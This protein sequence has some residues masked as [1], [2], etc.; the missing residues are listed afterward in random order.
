MKQKRSKE[1]VYE[2]V[3]Q[4]KTFLTRKIS[5]YFILALAVLVL[6]LFLSSR[7]NFS[8]QSIFGQDSMI[9]SR[10]IEVFS[11]ISYSDIFS[12]Y[13]FTDSSLQDPGS[14]TA[15][16]VLLNPYLLFARLLSGSSLVLQII[17]LV[18]S[19]LSLW[20]FYILLR[21]LKVGKLAS[22]LSV[23][24][25]AL[26][27]VFI[28][29]ALSISSMPLIAFLFLVSGIF[30]KKERFQFISYIVSIIIL[31]F[32]IEVAIAYLFFILAIL[33][34]LNRIKRFYVILFFMLVC[35]AMLSYFR[36]SFGIADFPIFSSEGIL[37]EIVSEFGGLRSI[38][39]MTLAVFCFE[40]VRKFFE[41]RIY[42]LEL[43]LIAS[44]VTIFFYEFRIYYL[45]SFGIALIAAS[46]ISS[47][48]TNRW[49]SETLRRLTILI[50][51]CGI[52]F[53][54]ISYSNVILAVEPSEPQIE[55]LDWLANQDK[56]TVFSLP[57]KS[58]IIRKYSS[59]P[60]LIDDTSFNPGVNEDFWVLY[61]SRDLMQTRQILGKHNV[62][63]IWIDS[64]MKEIVW[65]KPDDGLL[66]LFRNKETF[67]LIYLDEGEVEIWEVINTS[68]SN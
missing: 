24:I 15:K 41:K 58:E 22:N 29:Y 31:G 66:F 51:F 34:H 61:D 46:G 13:I 10:H 20:L 30:L 63:Y 7:I 48:Y 50:V 12:K 52:I 4:F 44:V 16:P 54:A 37:H 38:G 2:G 65:E 40:F 14:I 42:V 27:P 62:K 60:T 3:M 56:G 33:I 23:L 17:N 19:I 57:S 45:L 28:Y 68:F 11:E 36:I 25:L 67:E 64:D 55:S 8:S 6:A 35:F 26:S 43:I 39:V 21:Q 18:L 9:N 1:E 53:S 32:G 5:I 47:F 49:Y 59:M